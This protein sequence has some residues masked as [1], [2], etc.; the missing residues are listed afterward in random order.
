MITIDHSSATVYATFSEPGRLAVPLGRGPQRRARRDAEPSDSGRVSRADRQGQRPH[1]RDRASRATAR[2]DGRPCYSPLNADAPSPSPRSA[3]T[4]DAGRRDNSRSRRCG[5]D[6][7]SRVCVGLPRRAAQEDDTGQLSWRDRA[8]SQ[9]ALAARAQRTAEPRR[10]GLAFDSGTAIPQRRRTSA[11]TAGRRAAAQISARRP[12]RVS[13]RLLCGF[14]DGD[15]ARRPTCPPGRG[16]VEGHRARQRGRG[17]WDLHAP[18]RLP[19]SNGHSMPGSCPGGRTT[20]PAWFHRG[21]SL[22]A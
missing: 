10:G 9:D 14:L 20:P 16:Q 8:P 15:R 19:R 17:G 6:R 22:L 13:R 11:W 12:Q 18:L 7:R 21:A 2:E 5:S 3:A 1:S 4:A